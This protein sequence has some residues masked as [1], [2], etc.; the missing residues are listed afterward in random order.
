MRAPRLGVR[1]A[2]RCHDN[3]ACGGGLQR[4]GFTGI[5][6]P[7]G[8]AHDPYRGR[9]LEQFLEFSEMALLILA[10]VGCFI[11]SALFLANIGLFPW[12][13]VLVSVPIAFAVGY[14]LSRLLRGAGVL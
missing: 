8:G 3:H 9:C 7:P 6:V 2:L 13:A 1:N 11:I 12:I 14:P 4:P 5:V 10:L